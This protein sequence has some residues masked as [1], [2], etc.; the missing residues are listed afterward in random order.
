MKKIL[1]LIVITM[2][3][4]FGFNVHAEGEDIKMICV[5]MDCIYSTLNDNTKNIEGMTY[6][7][8]TN[9][10]TVE[11]VT[12]EKFLYLFN[13]GK[14]FK[15]NL[16]GENKMV[17][18]I[19]SDSS[20]TIVGE[21][22]LV[23]DNNN[24]HNE[25]FFDGVAISA[26]KVVISNESTVKLY[27]QDKVIRIYDSKKEKDLI[28]LMNGDDISKNIIE[29]IVSTR[30]ERTVV[31]KAIN[32]A[33]SPM[34]FTKVAVKDGKKY[35][36]D[37]YPDGSYIMYEQEIFTDQVNNTYF[38][39]ASKINNR[40]PYA[41]I[42]EVNN[43]GYEVIDEEVSI[44]EYT[45]ASAE[46]YEDNEKNRYIVKQDDTVYELTDSFYTTNDNPDV[47]IYFIKERNDVD[48]DSLNKIIEDVTYETRVDL[49]ELIV[50]PKKIDNPYTKNQLLIFVAI[51]S[52]VLLTVSFLFMKKGN[53]N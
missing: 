7:E 12:L 33:A 47:K 45:S 39:D 15:L 23:V 4:L 32:S 11:N 52:S 27:A 16:I 28:V 25:P 40:I 34:H 2:I 36:I 41:S 43:A 42:T 44:L 51:I 29:E 14:D 5:D 3:G 9:T 46:I 38:F 48:K 26:D 22:S 20:I 8:K 30:Y 53:Y 13:V 10:L 6:D 1:F 49:K 31:G 50:E 37:S 18:I 35:A 19:G 17:Q 21:G 24:Y